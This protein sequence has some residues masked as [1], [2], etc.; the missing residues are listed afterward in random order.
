MRDRLEC[1]LRRNKGS[2]SHQFA[3]RNNAIELFIVCSQVLIEQK[4]KQ[5]IDGKILAIME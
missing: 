5:L 2:V 1:L 4:S 3:E